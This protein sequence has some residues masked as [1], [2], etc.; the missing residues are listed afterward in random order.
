MRRFFLVLIL[1]LQT[2]SL[3]QA[4]LILVPASSVNK[5]QLPKNIETNY[6]QI[7]FVDDFSSY[8][9]LPNQ[10]KWQSTNVIVNSNYQFNPPTVGVVTLDVID[11]FGKLYPNAT[12]TSFEADTLLSQPIRLDSIVSPTRQKLSKSDSI[13][14]SFY[15]QPAGSNGQPWETIG[16]LPSYSDSIILDFFSPENGWEKV[17]AMGGIPLDSLFAQ[18]KA[19][20]KYVMIPITEDKYFTKE[21]RFR[22]RNIASLNNNPQL[23]YIGNCDQWNIDYVYLDKNR[24]ITDTV[25]RELA[26][27]DPAPSM[28]KRYQAMPAN[29]YTEQEI[30]DSLQ[31][32]IINLYSEALSSVYKYFIKDEQENILHTYDGGFENISP[33]ITTL[34]YQDALSHCRPIV[35]YN[36]P[37]NE[38]NWRTFSIIHTIKEGVGQDV[39]AS[40][41]TIS[42][43]QKFENYFAYDDGSAENGIGVEPIAGSHLAVAFD[44]NKSD[45]LTAVDIYF[46]SALNEAN[47]KQFYLCVWTSLNGIPYQMI[48]KTERLTPI[49]DSLNRFV[50]FELGEQMVLE[51]GVFF[52]S[53]QTKGNDYLNIGF[54]RNTNSSQY[55]YSKTGVNWEQSFLKGSIML[56]PYFGYK[57]LVGLN[58][59]DQEIDFNFYPNPTSSKIFFQRINDAEKQ[60]M[61]MNG[62]LLFSTYEN[63]IDLSQLSQ[64]IYILRVENKE[65]VVA[66]RKIVK[67]K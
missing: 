15:I 32:K 61:D 22:F 11:I 56:R 55:I 2:I 1:V 51:E 24:S 26:F 65:G 34:S 59:A 17:W 36:F 38:D 6:N 20:Y 58:E 52:I 19:Y 29:Q 53:L 27:V 31:I 48:H 40:N 28:L 14:F 43:I 13:Y 49:S 57:A 7:P 64:G 18:E 3:V 37:I 30:A 66:I 45:T 50:R 46:N 62:R 4:Q 44:L 33:Y 21:F 63:E 67:T 41:D 42:F 60:I 39:L 54:D 47:L 5:Q 35:D 9:G 8:Q 16:S 25:I 10:L 23:A 12:T